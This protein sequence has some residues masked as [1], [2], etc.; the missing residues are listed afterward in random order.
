MLTKAMRGRDFLTIGALDKEEVDTI[1]DV[2]AELKLERARGVRHHLLKDKTLFMLFYNRSL[3]TR[4]SFECGMTQLGGHANYLDSSTVYTP[5]MA[6]A[7]SAFVTERIVD[8]ANVLSR[9]GD[10]IAVRIFGDSTSWEYGQGHAY[11]EEFAAAADIPVI[12]MEDDVS[13]PTQIIADLLTLREKLGPLAGRKVVISWAYSPSR[14]KPVSVPQSLM[15]GC[16]LYG[17]NIVLARPSG[18]ELDPAEIDNAK[19]NVERFGGSF[20]ETD[21]LRAAFDNADVLYPKSWP[22]LHLLPPHSAKPDWDAQDR[23]FEQHHEWCVD[24]ELMKLT[25]PDSLYMHCLPA[26]RGFEVTDAVIDGAHSV[27]YDQAENRLHGEKA[28]MSLIM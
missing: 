13:H 12:N 16:S 1:L 26:D 21:D 15:V 5:S 10:A 6:G 25:K 8:V 28:V 19:A 17:A 9:Y 11:L 3:R 20:E 22:S 24:E 14:R 18:F 7:E 27:V 4:N 23:L 2:A